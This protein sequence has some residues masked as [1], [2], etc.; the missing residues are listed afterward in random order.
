MTCR[1]VAILSTLLIIASFGI[2][3]HSADFTSI[4]GTYVL[5]SRQ[6]VDGTTLVQPTV[7]GLYVISGGYMSFNLAVKDNQGKIISRSAIATYKISGA[8]Y[9]VELL[10]DAVN[11]GTGMKYDFSKKQ[12]SSDMVITDGRVEM[13][14]PLSDNLYGSFGENSLTV[15]SRGKYIDNWVKVN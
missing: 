4:E 8:T 9:A 14:I 13:K 11:D 6:L 12:G 3:S 15:M 5:K 10:Y 1:L 7:A 2:I